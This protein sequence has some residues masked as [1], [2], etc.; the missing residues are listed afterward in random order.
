[1]RRTIRM[2]GRSEPFLVEQIWWCVIRRRSSSREEY[3]AIPIAAQISSS[4]FQT[5]LSAIAD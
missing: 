2:M 3:S 4:N 1:M 5:F